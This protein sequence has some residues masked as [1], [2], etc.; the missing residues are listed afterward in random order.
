MVEGKTT[1]SVKTSTKERLSSLGAKG[2]TFDD[3]IDRL[4]NDYDSQI[5]LKEGTFMRMHMIRNIYNN[6]SGLRESLEEDG[7]EYIDYILDDLEYCYTK[8]KEDYLM[9]IL[10]DQSVN[11]LV[12]ISHDY[13]LL[14]N[15][16]PVGEYKKL[17]V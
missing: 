14:G 1:I 10:N 6:V 8:G 16:Y 11:E 3:I 7:Y 2:D 5:V 13:R 9:N 12:S 4:L 17:T 15:D